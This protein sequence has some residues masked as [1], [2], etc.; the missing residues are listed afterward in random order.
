MVLAIGSLMQQVE[1][2]AAAL[3]DLIRKLQETTDLLPVGILRDTAS[4]LVSGLTAEEVNQLLS[5]V[6]ATGTL[7]GLVFATLTLFEALFT[8][9]SLFVVAYFWISERL[10]IRRLVL[11]AVPTAHRERT[12]AIWQDVESKLGSWVLGQLFL[13]LVI[14]VL[15]GLGYTAMGLRFALLLA[16]F[17]MVAE[18]IPMVGPYIGAAPPI[19]VALTQDTNLALM[20]AGY[21]IVVHLIEANVLVPRDMQHAVDCR[22]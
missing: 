3:P 15:M 4:R 9:F 22:R 8:T 11:R 6:V 1:S 21:T 2:L 5:S 17:A 20:L 19:L 13:M 10:T 7:S 16:V 14:G 12:L 18:A